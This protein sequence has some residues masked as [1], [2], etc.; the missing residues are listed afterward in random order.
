MAHRVV[1]LD[2]T[3]ARDGEQISPTQTGIAQVAV[4]DLTTNAQLSL[5]V[6]GGGDPLPMRPGFNM[7]VCG[8][9][10]RQPIKVTHPAQP[11]MS[12]KVLLVFGGGTMFAS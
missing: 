5:I 9:D 12:A 4:L 8:D 6:G 2:L 10:S 1:T 7:L 11:G 3:N